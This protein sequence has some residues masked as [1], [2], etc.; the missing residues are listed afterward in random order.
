[1]SW[2]V[3]RAL[4]REFPQAQIHGLFRER[5]VEAAHVFGTLDQVHV[6]PSAAIFSK[7]F[8]EA[9]ADMALEGVSGF[10]TQMQSEDFDLIL[11]FSFSPL[12]SYLTTAF[13]GPKTTAS[14]YQRHSDGYLNLADD[15][16][17]YFYAQVGTHLH[18]RFHVTDLMGLLAKVDLNDEDSKFSPSTDQP[19]IL[20]KHHLL[21]KDFI[22]F[23]LGASEAHK[24]LTPDFCRNLILQIKVHCPEFHLV[25]VGGSEDQLAATMIEKSLHGERVLNL[26]GMTTWRELRDIFAASRLFIGADSGPMHLAGLMQA[27]VLNL[28]VGAVNFWETGPRFPGATLLRAADEQKL[29]VSEVLAAA[30]SL[31][32]GQVSRVGY[33]YCGGTPCFNAQGNTFEWQLIQAIYLSGPY[34]STDR[35]AFVKAVQDLSELNDLAIEALRKFRETQLEFLGPYLDRIYESM[36]LIAKTDSSISI[37]VNWIR[38]EKCRIPPTSP[39]EICDSYSDIHQ[40]L[41]TLLQPYILPRELTEGN[42]GY[43]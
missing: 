39:L 20:Q 1:M 40:G 17:R 43:G 19:Q 7:L 28:S 4:R 2:P 3:L 10:L 18:N 33:Q 32:L 23:H 21:G 27:P 42:I 31:L 24:R 11:N 6:L 14:G 26:V 34:P 9:S 16:S 12:S 8:A 22:V 25:L 41:K 30:R 5:F 37:F 36:N 35:M 13:C 38:A 29:V 15:I